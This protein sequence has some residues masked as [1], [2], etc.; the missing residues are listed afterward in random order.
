MRLADLIPPGAE[1]GAGLALQHQ[2]RYLFMLAGRRYSRSAEATF[3]AGIGGHCEP[4]EGWPEC[5]RR[6]AQEE[7]GAEVRVEEAARTVY[8]GRDLALC[9]VVVE[10][11]PRPLAVYELWNPPE[12]PWNKRG[13]GFVYY[14]VIYA[15]TLDDAVRPQVGDLDA[16]LWLSAAQV[17][18]TAR[19]AVTLAALLAEGARMEARA[20][21]PGHWLVRPQGTAHALALLWAAPR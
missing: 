18:H 10:D 6:E 15:A 11:S 3:Y 5:A 20:P 9:E 13:Q 4:G 8:V 12:A 21:L 16:I 14:V 7:L 19:E 17:G 1:T 2:G